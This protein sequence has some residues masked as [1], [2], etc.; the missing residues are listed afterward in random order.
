MTKSNETKTI[1]LSLNFNNEN[2]YYF[3]VTLRGG[4]GYLNGISASLEAK[5]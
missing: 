1:S 5:I 2:Q 4:P 3:T